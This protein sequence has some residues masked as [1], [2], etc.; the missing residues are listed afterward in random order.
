MFDKKNYDRQYY[1][2]HKD[3]WKKRKEKEKHDPTYQ[4]KRKQQKHDYYIA[5]RDGTWQPRPQLFDRKKWSHD[6]WL[7]HREKRT[8]QIKEW[9][10]NH[11]H[12]RQQLRIKWKIKTLT[13]YGNGKLACVECGENRL[14]CLS[15]D[16]I[17]NGGAL[18]RKL[19]GNKRSSIYRVL[20]EEG[21]PE[22]YQTLC[23]NCQFIK[24]IAIEY[25]DSHY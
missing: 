11:P 14:P 12:Y 6:Y 7:A 15:L 4:E 2:T 20:G 16:H 24:K 21:Y 9:E 22:G 8:K 3:K 19:L 23:M 17:T 1:L 5:K 10:V 18:H 13:H 25:Q